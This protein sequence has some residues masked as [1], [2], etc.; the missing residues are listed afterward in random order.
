M[1]FTLAQ[2]CHSEILVRKSRFIGCVQVVSSR[3]EAQET[4]AHL[5]KTHPTAT[6]I[7]WALLAGGHSAAV[8]DGEPSGTA[9]RP[10]LE[11]LRKQSLEGVLASAVRYYGGIPLGSGGLIRAYSECISTALGTTEKIRLIPQSIYFCQCPLALESKFRHLLA[12]IGGV[13]LSVQHSE[14]THMHIRIADEIAESLWQQA[15]EIS[16]G[17]ILWQKVDQSPTSTQNC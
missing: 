4:I 5:R 6:H 12:S 16:R 2:T 7:C 3:S 15:R 14:S 8:D 9:G 13:L 1:I 11:I 10:M 17:S